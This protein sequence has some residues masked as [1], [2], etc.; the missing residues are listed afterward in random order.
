MKYAIPEN[1]LNTRQ[2]EIIES[3]DNEQLATAWYVWF[4]VANT[5]NEEFLNLVRKLAPKADASI[6]SI[7]WRTFRLL[8]IVTYGE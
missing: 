3:I 1:R 4:D 8:N 6:R 2:L 5:L 7:Q